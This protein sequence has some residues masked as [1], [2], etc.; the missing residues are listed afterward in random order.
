MNDLNFSGTF[1]LVVYCAETKRLGVAVASG[2]KSV[3]KRVPHV[4]PGVG[5]VA[6][7]AYTRIFY[8][9]KGLELMS[10]GLKTKQVLKRLLKND[11]E[12]NLRQ[13]A[14]ID[15]K[16]R[17]ST[18][19]GKD[20]PEWKG[21]IQGEGYIAIGNLLSGE[22]VLRALVNGFIQSKEKL[23][24]R[25][26]NALEMASLIGGDRRGE[27]SAALLLAEPDNI[28]VKLMVDEDKSPIS[29]LIEKLQDT[30][31]SVRTST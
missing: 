31:N 18:F 27:R 28:E 10:R 19:T 5:A 2:S 24:I 8:G 15:I 6:T 1:S 13:V 30:Y 21:V 9:R 25:M 7:Q 22:E 3:G 20:A 14:M 17:T 12:S 16:G 23:A 4:K 26:A 29:K 11:P